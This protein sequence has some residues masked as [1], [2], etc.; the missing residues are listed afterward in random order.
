[1]IAN[2]QTNTTVL[3]SGR[4]MMAAEVALSGTASYVLIDKDTANERNCLL[5]G[6]ADSCLFKWH[7]SDYKQ[8]HFLCCFVYPVHDDFPYIRNNHSN[9]DEKMRSEYNL[10]C[11]L[12]GKR[13]RTT[14]G[15]RKYCCDE[16]KQ[17]ARRATFRRATNK[18]RGKAA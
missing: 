10:I 11:R 1:M 3:K 5:F 8:R 16:C 12:C 7:C 15:R 6:P 9:K 14:D 13:Y 17:A 18:R 2:F 4:L